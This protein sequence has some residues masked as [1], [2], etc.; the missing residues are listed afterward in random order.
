LQQS[1]SVQDGIAIIKKLKSSVVGGFEFMVRKRFGRLV[2]ALEQGVTSSI[3]FT[4]TIPQT[5]RFRYDSE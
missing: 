2:F 3:P 1:L 5:A 4:P